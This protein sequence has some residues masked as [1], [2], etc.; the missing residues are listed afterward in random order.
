MLMW[1]CRRGNL[2]WVRR[3]EGIG[4]ALLVPGSLALISA[5]FSQQGVAALSGRGPASRLL[6]PRSVPCQEDGL[7][8]TVRGGGRF[9]SIFRQAWR[10]C[11]SLYGKSRKAELASKA[12]SRGFP[13]PW[14][15][16][17]ELALDTEPNFQLIEH[18][19]DRDAQGVYRHPP[20][21]LK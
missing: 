8:S 2:P 15:I 17:V 6:P 14:T 3:L 5:N 20:Q 12:R 13:A 16:R 9:L 19:C 11:G 21:F 7:S 4:G 18:E 1:L 10:S